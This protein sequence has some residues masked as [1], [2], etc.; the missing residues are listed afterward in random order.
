[1][2]AAELIAT[3]SS[4]A[5]KLIAQEAAKLTAARELAAIGAN[6]RRRQN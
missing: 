4:R 5:A 1:V 6:A 2:E 3:T